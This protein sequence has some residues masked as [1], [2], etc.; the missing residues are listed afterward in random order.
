[1]NRGWIWLLVVSAGCAASP[2]RVE[3]EI[4]GRPSF[5]ISNSPMLVEP[6]AHEPRID[7]GNVAVRYSFLIESFADYP[8]TVA[9][10]RARASISGRRPKVVCK[11][12]EH[13]L[14]E[15][16]LEAHG[17]YRIDCDFGFTLREVPLGMLGDAVARISIP[18]TLNGVSDETTFSYFFRREDAS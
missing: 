11:V 17:R 6:P 16:L 14:G 4:F 12:A 18:M 5:A 10:G 3:R 2:A 13:A 7:N 8:Q 1:M 9:L 15:L